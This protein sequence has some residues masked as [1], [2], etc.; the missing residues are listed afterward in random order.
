M[1][2]RAAPGAGGGF[3]EGPASLTCQPPCG[4]VRMELDRSARSTRGKRLQ[5]AI[6]EEEQAADDQFWSQGFFAEEHVDDDYE[7]EAEEEDVP[8]SDFDDDVRWQAGGRAQ[9][10][11]RC[12]L[13]QPAGQC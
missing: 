1:S 5:A 10:G 8:D 13:G 9:R 7:T 12:N 11:G 3:A 4:S 2:R 6:Q